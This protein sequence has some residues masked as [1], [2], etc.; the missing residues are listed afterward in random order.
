MSEADPLI[1]CVV[2]VSEGRNPDTLNALTAAIRDTPECYLLH[3]DVGPGAHRT[4]FTFAGKPA[5]VFEAAYRIYAVADQRIDM[6]QHRGAHPRSGAVDVCP[7]VPVSGISMEEV[8]AGAQEL[9]RRV[10]GSFNLPIYLYANSALKSDRFNLADVRRGE[11]E[12]LAEKMQQP[13]GEPDFGPL[14]P[15]P[16]LGATIMGAR[17]FLIAWN[18]NL[19]PGATLQQARQ[20]AARLRGSGTKK[21]PG[22]FPGLKA[23]GW[24]IEEYGRY[25]VSCN[26]VDPDTVSL[27]RVYLTAVHLAQDMGTKVTGSELIGLVP[28]KHL[29]SAA[30]GF[31]IDGTSDEELTTAV[32]VLGLD[33]LRPFNWSDRVFETVFRA[34]A[35]TDRPIR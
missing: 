6:R 30:K 2:N 11:F 4:V 22:L 26:V 17:P 1:E 14:L 18:I 9:A 32:S 29:R 10:A 20:L 8:A 12:G 21:R 25:Q 31:C 34:A 7:F 35:Q 5:A 27:A 33:D 16:R 23:I 3:R 19:A 15:H 13:G 28:A 24:F